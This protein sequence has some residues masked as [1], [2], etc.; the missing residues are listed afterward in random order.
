MMEFLVHLWEGILEAFKG[1]PMT[2]SISFIAVVIGL[3]IGFLLALMREAKHKVWRVISMVYTDI[4][5]GTP[6]VVQIFIASY[7]IPALLQ[8][9][10]VQFKWA[11]PAYPAIVVCGLN[12]A[13]YMGEII[14]AGLEAI[15]IGQHEA[16]LSLGMTPR[17]VNRLVVIPQAIKIIMPA[18]GNELV[19]MIKETSVLSF[20]AVVEIMRR[21]VL[22][23]SRTFNF[24]SCYIGVAIVY[25][26]FTIP[27]SKL[28]LLMEK[29]LAE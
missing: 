28:V 16:A 13:A 20:A 18:I 7:G 25:M 5:R 3:V 26:V 21:G 2:L 29:K 12:S 6:L 19:T 24:F 14:R 17:Q 9:Y 8:A 15:D 11:D 23:A 22:L 4:V 10:G 1:A 27:L